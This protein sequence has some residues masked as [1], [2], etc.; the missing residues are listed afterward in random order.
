MKNSVTRPTTEKRYYE[1][2]SIDGE[3]TMHRRIDREHVL[4]T[5]AVLLLSI[6]CAILLALY[7]I[8]IAGLRF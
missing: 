2:I 7:C 5:I 1:V 8:N 6:A 4:L 3:V